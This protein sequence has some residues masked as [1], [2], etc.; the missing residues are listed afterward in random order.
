VSW[1]EETFW[2]RRYITTVSFGDVGYSSLYSLDF[3]N[4]DHGTGAV[5]LVIT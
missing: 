1:L 2:G 5:H 3:A 4:R